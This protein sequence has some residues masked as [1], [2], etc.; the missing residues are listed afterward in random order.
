M[1]LQEKRLAFFNFLYLLLTT[2]DFAHA[3]LPFIKS[4]RIFWTKW[5]LQLFRQR[6]FTNQN[7]DTVIKL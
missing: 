2:H 1:L 7:H 6:S 3:V 4:A 5:P